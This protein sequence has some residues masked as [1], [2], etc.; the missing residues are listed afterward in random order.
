M[1]KSGFAFH[2]HHDTLFEWCYD[3]DRRVEY[4]KNFKPKQERKLRLRLFKLIPEDKLPV[5]FRK[6]GEAYRKA[7]EAYDK[8]W[9]A[10]RKD[11]E[12]Y[13]KAWEAY[14]KAWEAYRKAQKAYYKAQKAYYKAQK[15][16]TTEIEALHKELC[17]DC[18][19]D[20]KSIFG[21]EET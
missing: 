13:D 2:V 5:R 8:A 7:W 20:G 19:W 9:E 6:A 1:K 16:Y 3:Y 14:R 12:A 17:P 21:K 10:Y 15:A 18:P 4:I 11:W